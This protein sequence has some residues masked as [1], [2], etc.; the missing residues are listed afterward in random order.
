M[1]YYASSTKFFRIFRSCLTD[2]ASSANLSS[3]ISAVSNKVNITSL[4][5][6][7]FITSIGTNI[8]APEDNFTKWSKIPKLF[9][10]VRSIV[11]EPWAV[12]ATHFQFC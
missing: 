1:D 2:L 10:S 7:F 12:S 6:P 5:S 8:T 4:P 3:G 11:T 9:L